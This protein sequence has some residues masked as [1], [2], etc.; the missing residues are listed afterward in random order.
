MTSRRVA[1]L[2]Q[3]HDTVRGHNPIVL[4]RLA[5]LDPQ[6]LDDKYQGDPVG[7]CAKASTR[8]EP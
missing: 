4:S 1:V 6:P 2:A 3:I 5:Q 7:Q 8:R